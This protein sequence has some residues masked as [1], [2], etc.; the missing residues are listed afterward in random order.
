MKIRF[1]VG[2]AFLTL[3]LL[4]SAACG[5]KNDLTLPPPEETLTP[6]NSAVKSSFL[7]PYYLR[8]PH[9]QETT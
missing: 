5:K 6:E 1:Y 9:F 3:V 8:S 4:V 7:P 2:S